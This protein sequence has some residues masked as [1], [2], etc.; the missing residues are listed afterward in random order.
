MY[1]KQIYTNETFDFVGKD[2]ASLRVSIV[3]QIRISTIVSVK[4]LSPKKKQNGQ[5]SVLMRIA[6]S[7]KSFPFFP[8]DT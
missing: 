6:H 1:S 5:K 3:K 8:Y 2:V 7:F 4:F